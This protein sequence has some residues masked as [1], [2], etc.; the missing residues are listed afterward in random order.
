MWPSNAYDVLPNE[1]HINGKLYTQRIKPE[2]LHIR[3][4]PKRKT[5]EY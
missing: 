3:N 2:N 5:L 1:K 4:R